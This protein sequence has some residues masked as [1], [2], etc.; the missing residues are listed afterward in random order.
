MNADLIARAMSRPQI[1]NTIEMLIAALD[2]MDAPFED[3]EPEE[4]HGGIGEEESYFDPLH[5]LSIS[6]RQFATSSD[7]WSL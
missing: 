7:R 3:M 5:P 2:A 1:E 4:D 6:T